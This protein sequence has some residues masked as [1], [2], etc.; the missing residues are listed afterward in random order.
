MAAEHTGAEGTM[1]RIGAVIGAAFILG[2]CCQAS[3]NILPKDGGQA[4]A[5]STSS[6][7]NCALEKAQAEA[8]DYCKK[9]GKRYVAINSET[10]YQGADPNAK[11]AIGVLTRHSGNSSDDYRVQL[12][13]KCE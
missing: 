9:E 12:D 2:G 6:K 13:F 3:V 11:L 8:D 5:I 7:E 4:Q 1:R 10:K